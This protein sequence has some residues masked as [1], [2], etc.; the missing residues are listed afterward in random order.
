MS[1]FAIV[2]NRLYTM[3]FSMDKPGPGGKFEKD[4]E[5]RAAG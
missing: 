2:G 5:G 4:E 1:S 3:G